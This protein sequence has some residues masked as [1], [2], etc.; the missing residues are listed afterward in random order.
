MT[1]ASVSTSPSQY[2]TMK[3]R[4]KNENKS[5]KLPSATTI[6]FRIC[7]EEA[8]K[9]PTNVSSYFFEQGKR[10][11]LLVIKNQEKSKKLTK[12][13]KDDFVTRS[14]KSAITL[15]GS[16][17]VS[18]ITNFTTLATSLGTT[19]SMYVTFAKAIMMEAALLEQNFRN[20]KMHNSSV[21]EA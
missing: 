11:I 1:P 5:D 10:L 19:S 17:K 6:A 20:L 4:L 18:R 8:L 14:L 15:S 21:D 3:S 16:N 9:L 12:L 7:Q 13:Q 2:P